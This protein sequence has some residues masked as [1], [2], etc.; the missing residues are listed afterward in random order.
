MVIQ[1]TDPADYEGG[2]LEMFDIYEDSNEAQLAEFHAA[3]SQQGSAVVFP[4]FE[5]HRVVP[6]RQGR[7]YSLVAWV[8]GPPFR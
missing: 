2:E 1:L 3:S 8:S 7:R 6:L 4:A 5:Y